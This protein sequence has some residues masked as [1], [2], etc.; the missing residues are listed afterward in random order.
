MDEEMRQVRMKYNP[1]TREA[2]YQ[3]RKDSKAEWQNIAP[4]NN[5]NQKK[6]RQGIIL[7]NDAATI[8]ETMIGE[9]GKQFILVF[10][11]PDVDYNFLTTAIQ[12]NHAVQRNA[13]KIN[14]LLEKPISATVTENNQEGKNIGGEPSADNEQTEWGKSNEAW[15]RASLELNITLKFSTIHL[16]SILSK[17]SIPRR[18]QLYRFFPSKDIEKILKESLFIDTKVEEAN[19]KQ[20]LIGGYD[21]EL[22]NGSDAIY[23]LYNGILLRRNSSTLFIQYEEVH[24]VD[25]DLNGLKLHLEKGSCILIPVNSCFSIDVLKAIRQI[26]ISICSASTS[27]WNEDTEQFVFN[28][29]CDRVKSFVK[30]PD[31]CKTYTRLDFYDDSI[32]KKLR[33]ALHSYAKRVQKDDAVAFI[34]TSLF[35]N[36]KDGILFTAN[37]I[38]FDYAFEKVYLLYKEIDYI[39]QKKHDLVFHGFFSNMKDPNSLPSIS[40]IYFKL[41]ELKTCLDEICLHF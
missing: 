12:Q 39:E 21:T 15:R 40:D 9:F 19:R 34:D 5:L 22:L 23:F 8:I 35:S 16:E 13:V 11:G 10:C 32:D 25:I 14:L 7:K 6:R 26:L 38:A 24:G 29:L 36:G 1:D 18:N 20:N 17:N 28:I 2:L 4:E 33:N 31:S 3:T 37:G 41:S 27:F 30:S